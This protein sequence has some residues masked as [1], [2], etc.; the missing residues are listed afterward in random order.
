MAVSGKSTSHLKKIGRYDDWETPPDIFRKA[1]EISG[2][3]P[4]VDVS[5]T[6]HNAKCGVFIDRK[7]D[8]LKAEWPLV[9]VWCNPPY[10]KVAA[11]IGR[12]YEHWMD[13][14]SALCLTYNKTDTAWFHRYVWPYAR[15]W[16]W[17]RRIRF[18]K[19]G[20]EQG[21]APYPSML[22]AF[23]GSAE[24]Q[25][26]KN[27]QEN[28]V[29]AFHGIAGH[30]GGRIRGSAPERADAGKKPLR[31]MCPNCG[32]T[33]VNIQSCHQICPNCGGHTDCSD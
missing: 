21:P 6:R 11:W 1:C 15:I 32:H 2:I 7:A 3:T 28:G 25:T 17:P 27:S 10:S 26:W 24:K 13:G 9:P 30:K 19:K 12:I 22:F 29:A 16:W 31:H 33:M 20:V 18:M 5:A 14:G 4:V 23:Y 8:G